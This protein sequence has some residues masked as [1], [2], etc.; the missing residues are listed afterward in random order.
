MQMKQTIIQLIEKISTAIQ[1]SKLQ[2]ITK[3]YLN[4]NSAKTLFILSIFAVTTLM[5]NSAVCRQKIERHVAFI[6]GVSTYDHLAPLPNCINDVKVI[7]TAFHTSGYD[8]LPLLDITRKDF[9]KSL[10]S[11]VNTIGSVK[12]C[13]FWFDGH[14]GVYQGKNYIFLKD[15]NPNN[16]KRLHKEAV[17]LDLIMKKLSEAKIDVRVIVLDVCRVKMK[18][19]GFWRKKYDDNS[20]PAPSGFITIFSTSD[21][22]SALDGI[23]KNANS[24]FTLA[25]KDL[26]IDPN[27][28]ID[29]LMKLVI[30][31]VKT[32]TKGKQVPC[33]ESN[34]DFKFV[35]APKIKF[36]NDSTAINKTDTLLKRKVYAKFPPDNK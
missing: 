16:K 15:S 33:M 9:M 7:T 26:M 25:I 20:I 21:G 17:A 18:N 36:W 34:L 14:S 24:P 30:K 22:S 2:T 13:V 1:C 6:A 10:D 11:F 32:V 8:V 35:F 29:D 12:T 28:P 19:F 5:S 27:L 23:D 3:K 31:N 4:M